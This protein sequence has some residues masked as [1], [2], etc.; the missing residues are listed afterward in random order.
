M[1]LDWL[2]APQCVG[3]GQSASTLCPACAGS[4]LELGPACGRCAE[5]TAAGLCRRCATAPL[6]LEQILAPWQFGGQLAAAIRRLKFANGAHV[7]RDVA[8]LWAPLLAAVVEQHAAIVVPVPLHWKRRLVRGYDQA[9]L[10]AVHACAAAK[11]APPRSL[12]RRI[13]GAPAQSKLSAAQRRENLRGAF[14]VRTPHEVAGRTIVLVDDVVTTGATLAAAA[15]ALRAA[16]A[17]AIYGV[18]LARAGGFV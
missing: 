16:G 13:R 4:L 8:P 5:P 15:T 2:F 10:L 11:L 18:A 1:V 14:T 17:C 7:A 3:C 9:W 6:P 12:L